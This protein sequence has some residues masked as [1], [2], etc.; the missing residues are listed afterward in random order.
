MQSMVVGVGNG[1]HLAL[2]DC[3]RFLESITAL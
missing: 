3:L 2:W 1:H